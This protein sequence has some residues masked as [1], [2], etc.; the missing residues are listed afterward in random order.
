MLVYRRVVK[1]DHF[2]RNPGENTVENSRNHKLVFKLSHLL[3]GDI[4]LET[5]NHQRCEFRRA[6]DLFVWIFLYYLA[7]LEGNNSPKFNCQLSHEKD[8]LNFH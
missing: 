1:L 2:P 6:S 3:P 7:E 8:P 5:I 4:P